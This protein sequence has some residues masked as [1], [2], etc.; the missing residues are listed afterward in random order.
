M[1]SF[2]IY[3]LTRALKSRCSRVIDETNM[4]VPTDDVYFIKYYK[5]KVYPFAEAIQC[6]RETHHP[7]MYNKPDAEVEVRVELDTQ[8]EKKVGCV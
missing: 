7:D 3:H 6:H 8:G 4:K 5:M 2:L 1:Y